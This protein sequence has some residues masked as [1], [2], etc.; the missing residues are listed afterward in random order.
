MNMDTAAKL[1][2]PFEKKQ[3]GKL[4]K[5][6]CPTCRDKNKVC[7]E[8]KR[9]KCGTCKANIPS[10]H[11]HVDYVGHADVTDRLLQVDPGWNWEPLGFDSF[12]SP[13]FDGN[14]GLW[15]KLTIAEV[16]RLGYGHADNKKG[17]DA[18]K[19]AIG[20]AIRNAAMRFGVGLDLWRKETVVAEDEVPVREVERPAQT[21]EE[22][23]KE[24]R[25]QILTISRRKGRHE[26]ADIED[27]FT[28]WSGPDVL[29][30]HT[31]STG[32]LQSYLEHIQSEAG[33]P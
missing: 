33:A 29:Q 19:E 14:G 30:I 7:S 25:A 4:P 1:R 18:V 10:G 5:I 31:A 12:G 27:H 24:L 13:A 11:L 8:H 32:A 6:W 15:I 3:I 16:T 2:A 22:R 9:Q 17:G 26:V 28:Q 21:V 20:D 23:K